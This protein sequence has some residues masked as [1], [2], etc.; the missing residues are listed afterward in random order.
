MAIF[1]RLA[2]YSGVEGKASLAE[3]V[4]DLEHLGNIQYPKAQSSEQDDVGDLETGY[5]Q[6]LLV[7]QIPEDCIEA[8]GCPVT[9]DH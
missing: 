8:V 7:R 4:H 9:W 5:L 6:N 3:Y 2:L 1:S